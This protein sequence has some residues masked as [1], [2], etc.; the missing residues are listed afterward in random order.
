[1]QLKEGCRRRATPRETPAEQ[2]MEKPL[3][4]SFVEEK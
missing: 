4:A 2:A 1:M 3:F